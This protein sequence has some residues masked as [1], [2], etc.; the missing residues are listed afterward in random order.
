M[1]VFEKLNPAN[2]HKPVKVKTKEEISTKENT[3]PDGFFWN[4]IDVKK[5]G[6]L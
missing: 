3:L 5:S 1:K 2:F 6:D 4:Q